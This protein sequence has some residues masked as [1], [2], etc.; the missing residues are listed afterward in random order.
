MDH[1]EPETFDFDVFLSHSS[2]DKPVVR[3]LAERLR[4][5]GLR[6]WFDEWVIQL[7]D[8]IYAKISDGLER[9]RILLLCMSRNGFGSDWVTVEHQTI[10]FADPQNRKRRFIPIRLDDAN[11]PAVLRPYKYFDWRNPADD[12][13]QSLLLACKAAAPASEQGSTPSP[14]APTDIVNQAQSKPVRRSGRQRP[15]VPGP[16]LVLKGHTG[17]VQEIAISADGRRAVSGSSDDTVRVWD[18]EANACTVALEGHEGVV[19]SV[20]I[21]ADGRRAVSGSRDQTVR[22]WDLETNACAAV[23]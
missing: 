14:Q 3:A 20:G 19:D 10:F 12:A 2:N 9:S 21:T 7:G 22:V 16:G 15:T 4:R 17:S 11:I 5:D 13:Y 8:S 6:V 1:N 18:L 23:L